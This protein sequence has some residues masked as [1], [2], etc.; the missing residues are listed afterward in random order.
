MFGTTLFGVCFLPYSHLFKGSSAFVCKFNVLSWKMHLQNLSKFLL[1][2]A[3]LF[4]PIW[5]DCFCMLQ[6]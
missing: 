2:L 6:R 1:N 3:K 4:S 5:V